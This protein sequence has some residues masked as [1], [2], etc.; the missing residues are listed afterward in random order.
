M[1]P[2]KESPMIKSAYGSFKRVS[3]IRVMV[4]FLLC[5]PCIG[6]VECLYMVPQHLAVVALM[7][8]LVTLPCSVLWAL[9]GLQR[10]IQLVL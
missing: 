10:S 2:A 6:F 8:L 7:S 9:M 1:V 4:Y 5:V 3:E